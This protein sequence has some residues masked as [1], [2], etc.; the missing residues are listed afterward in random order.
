M[1][2]PDDAF[3][4]VMGLFASSLFGYILYNERTRLTRA[5]HR[6][7]HKDEAKSVEESIAKVE[8]SVSEVR[9][10][11]QNAEHSSDQYRQRLSD[12]VHAIR[13]QLA[14]LRTELGK[15]TD[16]TGDSGTFKGL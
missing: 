4:G 14:V 10:L 8:L 5:E 15:N 11:I 9:A 1:I 12:A 2:V 6:L 3:W 16:D 7:I 13:L